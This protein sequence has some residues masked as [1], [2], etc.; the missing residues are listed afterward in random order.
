MDIDVIEV[1]KIYKN[2]RRSPT[3]IV[4]SSEVGTACVCQNLFKLSYPYGVIRG[5]KDY[6][7]AN[8]VHDIMSL[9]IG[10]TI[11]ENWEFKIKDYQSLADRIMNQSSSIIES[12]IDYTIEV[13]KQE[14]KVI[15]ENYEDQVNDFTN[16]LLLSITKRLMNKFERPNGAITEVTITNTKNNQE[17]RIDA[18]LEYPHGYALLDWKTYDLGNTIS[19]HE[20][21]QLISNLLLANYRYTGNE[22]N[23]NRYIFSSIVHY[24]GAYFPRLETI[25]QE[26]QKIITNRNF[27]YNVLCDIKVRP[28]KPKFCPVCDTNSEGSKECRFYREDSKLAYEGLLPAQYDK[29]R[30]Q[31]YGKRYEI[32]KGRAET[33]LNKYLAENLINKYGE[34]KALEKLVKTGTI[35]LGY[36]YAYE[37]GNGN[38]HF[39]RESNN[40]DETFLE[41]TNIVRVIGK[42]HGIP[43]LCCI[44]EQASVIDVS[45]NSLVLKFRSKIAVERARK[46]LFHLPI[47]LLN[48]VINLTKIML[49]PIHEFHKLASD[50]FIHKDCLI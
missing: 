47:V 27:A 8:T 39:S 33:H 6:L 4:Q 32:L 46:Q 22:E 24:T 26:T 37:E 30:K 14:N 9:C 1:R 5:N 50:F 23:W 2:L 11:I 45:G 48:D 25:N 38:I 34:D 21:W 29:I 19:G 15:P 20:K 41:P 40:D 42:E 16:G 49:A 28:E 12:I 10:S 35:H 36:K 31:F 44:S 18:L 43:L 17:G 13:A 7:I 3:H